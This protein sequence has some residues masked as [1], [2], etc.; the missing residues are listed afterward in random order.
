MDYK[1]VYYEDELCHYGVKGMKW[2]VRRSYGNKAKTAAYLKKTSNKYEKKAAKFTKKAEKAT[3]KGNRD[4]AKYYNQVA[5]DMTKRTKDARALR[6]KLVTNLNQKDIKKGERAMTKLMVA[7]TIMTLPTFGLGT[8]S[9]AA[10]KRLTDNARV[11]KYSAQY[12]MSNPLISE[13]YK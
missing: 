2:G 10:A 12:K 1:N 11:T 6:N 7:S 13:L 8:A 4:Q 3:A 5:K 9:A